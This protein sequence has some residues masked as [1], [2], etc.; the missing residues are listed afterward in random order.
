MKMIN[1][2]LVVGL[3]I[4]AL[5]SPAMA[6]VRNPTTGRDAA[7]AACNAEAHNRYHGMYTSG[8]D[9]DRAYVY[10]DCMHDHGFAR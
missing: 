10:G 8:W 6:Q 5:A 3:A 1:I 4:A 9:Q 7:I 2:A